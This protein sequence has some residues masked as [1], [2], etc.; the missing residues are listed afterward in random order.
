MLLAWEGDKN[1]AL[2]ATLDVTVEGGESL[3]REVHYTH[4]TTVGRWTRSRGQEVEYRFRVGLLDEN[5]RDGKSRAEFT[6]TLPK[7]GRYRVAV[8]YATVG[9][10]ATNTPVQIAH[11][12]GTATVTVNQ[13][14]K[15][16]P[17]A[18]VPVGDYRFK[19]GE[20]ATVVFTNAGVNG[21]VQID[22]VRWLWLGD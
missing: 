11:A 14:K 19:A 10:R 18:F 15:D 4:A 20:P 7:S 2:P 3:N 17:F 5:K 13:R 8:A 12:D 9:N 22:T 6:T 1:F 16:S 21:Y